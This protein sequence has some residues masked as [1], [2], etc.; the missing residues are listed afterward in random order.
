[1]AN[2]IKDPGIGTK[3]DEKVRRMINADGSYNVI[4]KGSAKGI[5]DIFKYLVEISW[6]WFFTILFVGYI[7]F[8]LIFSLI[9]TY[10]GP[11]N[12]LGLDPENGSVFFQTFFFSIQT[13]TTVGYGTL[14]PLGIATQIVASIEAFVGFLS[15][16]LATGLLY[17]RFSRPRSKIKFADNFVFSKYEQGHSFK[18]KLTNLRDVVLQDVEAKIITMFNKE[19]ENGQ[20]VR[21]YYELPITL[22]KIDIMALTWTLVHKIDEES[23]FWNKSKEEII[24]Q[25]PEF[26]IFVNGFD[27]IYSER[28]R[29]RKSYVVKDILW[30]KNFTT[31]FKSL[32]NGKLLM[33]VRDLNNV[34]NE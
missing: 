4:K 34:E 20:L 13:F 9:Y 27:E 5:R 24:S 6:T 2:E 18:F 8:N 19:N 11:E 10:F 12:I 30:N 3:I 15:F 7:I 16:S 22:P 14:A 17:G 25:H 31:N 26:L 21:T 29:A 1:M 23:P 32:E 33:D 28:T